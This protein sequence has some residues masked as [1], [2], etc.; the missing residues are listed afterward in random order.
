M[1]FVIFRVEDGNKSLAQVYKISE[2]IDTQPQTAT[3][4]FYDTKAF[5]YP[6]DSTASLL[7]SYGSKYKVE[8]LASGDAKTLV[9]VGHEIGS[10][11]VLFSGKQCDGVTGIEKVGTGAEASLSLNPPASVTAF[12][13]NDTPAWDGAETD[14]SAA[15]Y[16]PA[17]T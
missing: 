7:T 16:T 9:D 3:R 5:L 8:W 12:T 13:P 15:S 11:A 1:W 6:G 17:Y 4:N 2:A 14:A 10:V